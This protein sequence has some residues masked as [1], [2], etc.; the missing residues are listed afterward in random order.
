MNIES[1]PE[2]KD[3]LYKYEEECKRI[4]NVALKSEM[5]KEFRDISNFY[6]PYTRKF[7][8]EEEDIRKIN[9]TSWSKFRTLEEY[10]DSKYNKKNDKI[11]PECRSVMKDNSNNYICTNQNCGYIMAI[12]TKTDIKPLVKTQIK[13]NLGDFDDLLLSIEGKLNLPNE[14][15]TM[16]VLNE[17]KAEM[18]IF[19]IQIYKYEQQL[20]TYA[21]LMNEH[22]EYIK[23]LNNSDLI[24]LLEIYNT[25]KEE[26]YKKTHENIPLNLFEKNDGKNILLSLFPYTDLLNQE[27]LSKYIRDNNIT[28]YKKPEEIE[29]NIKKTKKIVREDD[30]TIIN[31][32]DRNQIFNLLASF[33]IGINLSYIPSILSLEELERFLLLYYIDYQNGL[34]II[35]L[36]TVKDIFGIVSDRRD[37]L[38]TDRKNKK[39]ELRKYYIY[40]FSVKCFI[41]KD[42]P[43]D[44]KRISTNNEDKL[45]LNNIYHMI[46]TKFEELKKD[47]IEKKNLSYQPAII[48]NILYKNPKLY[49][50]YKDLIENIQVKKDATE[51][52]ITKRCDELLKTIS[53]DELEKFGI[54]I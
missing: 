33:G 26:E 13:R 42:Y 19:I 10:I 32:G 24:M 51:T 49:E 40:C 1:V 41:T 48:K 45:L 31:T 9:M 17:I 7:E 12:T 18:Y 25:P 39:I 50:K 46:L 22:R 14:R 21:L 23:S 53:Q 27:L 52:K 37:A 29:K 35:S 30:M 47:S 54:I 15:F 2:L 43:P 44:D 3:L 38:I 4:T 16:E 6:L 28:L 11:C 36:N 34:S 8:L 5:E 20:L